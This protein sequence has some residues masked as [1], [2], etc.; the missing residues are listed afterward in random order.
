MWI[1]RH[2]RLRRRSLKQRQTWLNRGEVRACESLQPGCQGSSRVVWS[3]Y[4]IL[5]AAPVVCPRF[6]APVDPRSGSAVLRATVNARQQ[7]TMPGLKRFAPVPFV[8]HNGA[9]NH[10]F[11]VARVTLRIEKPAAQSRIRKELVACLKYD[12]LVWMSTRTPLQ[13]AVAEPDGEVRPLGI[14]PN[15]LESVRKLVS[16]AGSGESVEGLL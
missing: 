14:I 10:R 3:S 9:T 8:S 6:Y 11:A 1:P 5:P 7:L 4:R 12:L 16:K 2:C 13:H 15:R